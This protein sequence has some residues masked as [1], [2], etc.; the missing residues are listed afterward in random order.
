MQESLGA[1]ELFFLIIREVF[2]DVL[3]AESTHC[4]AAR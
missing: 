1:K 3:I 4:Q 2:N